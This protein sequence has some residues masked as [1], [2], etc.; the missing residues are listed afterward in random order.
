MAKHPTKP[1]GRGVSICLSVRL[2]ACLLAASPTGSDTRRSTKCG[3]EARGALWRGL[4]HFRA[5]AG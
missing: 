1:W 5:T 4:C 2:P 3:H